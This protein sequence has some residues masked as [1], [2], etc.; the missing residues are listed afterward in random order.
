MQCT[1]LLCFSLMM[2]PVAG[3]R[4][5]LTPTA[6]T[7][8]DLTSDLAV[9]SDTP[10]AQ[11][12]LDLN[13][14]L[15]DAFS[16][17]VEFKDQRFS[18]TTS[19][20]LTHASDKPPDSLEL[21]ESTC[22]M[23]SML[24]TFKDDM[25]FEDDRIQEAAPSMDQV[26]DEVKVSFEKCIIANALDGGAKPADLFHKKV[27][28]EEVEVPESVYSDKGDAMVK[29]VED[30]FKRCTYLLNDERVHVDY[31]TALSAC[32][33]RV[34]EMHHAFH[35]PQIVQDLP[36][37]KYPADL[38]RTQACEQFNA[39]KRSSPTYVP[40]VGSNP[41]LSSDVSWLPDGWKMELSKNRPGEVTFQHTTVK[42]ARVQTMAQVY[43]FEEKWAAASMIEKSHVA[44]R[45][46]NT[47]QGV[48]NSTAVALEELGAGRGLHNSSAVSLVDVGTGRGTVLQRL[49]SFTGDLLFR[50]IMGC[51]RV[52][53]F[54]VTLPIRVFPS[55]FVA[56]VNGWMSFKRFWLQ[57][58][59]VSDEG[60]RVWPWCWVVPRHSGSLFNKRVC[61]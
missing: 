45:L 40:G 31:R 23:C 30:E 41:M 22:W 48:H 10:S 17:K 16:T 20:L 44:K 15:T 9:S 60:L 50:L 27:E 39:D 58:V 33:E 51:A 26:K 57:G 38:F 28:F 29:Q 12:L 3:R 5:S 55:V 13:A 56:I 49:A 59:G 34:Y 47:T 46:Q 25:G 24:E 42:E 36:P 43:K 2:L 32:S 8:S 21:Q 53:H 35:K 11:E 19:H 1:L 4:V 14:G 52:V 7:K 37:P 54:I 6:M 18:E 61:R